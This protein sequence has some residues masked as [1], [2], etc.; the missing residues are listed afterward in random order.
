MVSE[1]AAELPHPDRSSSRRSAAAPAC[2][3]DCLAASSSS[4][5]GGLTSGDGEAARSH[6]G[7]CLDSSV[8]D[9][10]CQRSVVAFVLIGVR[11]S[12]IRYRVVELGRIAEV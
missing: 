11:L 5:A 4:A 8:G 10:G 2:K 7:L 3:A 6:S 1:P 9:S 12:E